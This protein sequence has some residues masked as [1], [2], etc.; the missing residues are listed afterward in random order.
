MPYPSPANYP[1]ALLNPPTGTSATLVS[2]GNLTFG[3]VDANGSVWTL[4][5][6]EGWTGSPDPTL[7]LTQRSRADG[8]TANESFLTA[9]NMVLSGV[10]MAPSPD[11]L[12]ASL[13]DLNTAVTLAPF[14]LSVSESGRVRAVMAQRNGA[15]LTPKVNSRFARFSIQVVAKDPL[16]YGAS[17]TYT[18]PLPSSSGG[19]T[20]PVT[21]PVTYTGVTN[22]GVISVNNP[23]NAPA[24][25]LLR[26][27]GRIPVGG[28]SVNHLGQD[29]TLSFA[30]SL[31]LGAGEFVTVDMQRREVLAQGQSTR[32]GYVT[33]RGW[34]QLDPGPNDIAF[35][36]VAY[37]SSA[38]LTLT[39]Y[40]AWS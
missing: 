15:V 11:A 3:A 7:T 26:I 35:S 2:V 31:S 4:T 16:K 5:N 13:D 34:F 12:N 19:V 14:Q 17:A 32:N 8:A 38:L 22:T 37:D 18:T 30:T 9:R 40:P 33:S 29:L 36:S 6:F 24:P 27:D 1:A 10:V 25:V 39:T 20:Y 28:W 23:G 21:Y